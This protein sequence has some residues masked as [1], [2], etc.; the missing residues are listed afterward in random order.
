MIT[1]FVQK[2]KAYWNPSLNDSS[3]YRGRDRKVMTPD[4]DEYEE[5]G[6]NE[7]MQHRRQRWENVYDSD[8]SEGIQIREEES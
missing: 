1:L 2:I 5:Y 4:S 8:G 7:I 3:Q 6:I